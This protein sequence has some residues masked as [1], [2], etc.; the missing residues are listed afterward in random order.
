MTRIHIQLALKK[1]KTFGKEAHSLRLVAHRT[2][3]GLIPSGST[4][5]KPALH[6]VS[7]ISAASIAAI[8]PIVGSAIGK[9]T[10]P[11]IVVVVPLPVPD[12]AVAPSTSCPTALDC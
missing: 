2:L 12:V 1:K 6:I 8:S 3:L 7:A 9:V 5:K 10:L 4:N 11:E